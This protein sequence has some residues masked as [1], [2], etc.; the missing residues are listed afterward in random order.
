[1]EERIMQILKEFI[2]IDSISDSPKE[3]PAARYIYN[4]FKD[5]PY[6]KEHP[7]H[8]GLFE[9]PHDPHGRSVPYARMRTGKTFRSFTSICHFS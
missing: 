5:M 2:A 4:F 9:I 7:D 8:T 1:M 3:E 6:F